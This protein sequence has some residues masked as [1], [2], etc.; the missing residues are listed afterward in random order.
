MDSQGFARGTTIFSPRRGADVLKRFGLVTLVLGMAGCALEPDSA[1]ALAGPSELGLSLEIS[2]TP[3]ILTQDG[4]SKA[5]IQVVAR[6]HMGQ[7]ASGVTLRAETAVGQTI[8]DFGTLSTSV[9]STGSD[10]RTQLTYTAPPAPPPGATNDVVVS[11]LVTPVG[12]NYSNSTTRTVTIRLAR[13]GT[14]LPPNGTPVPKFF[15]SP[16]SPKEGE[17]VLFDGSASTDDGTIVSYTWN[18]GDGRVRTGPRVFH[19]Y[20]LAG[21]YRVTLTVTDD[22]GFTA[23]SAPTDVVVAAADAPTADFTFSPTQPIAGQ[24]VFFNG[25]V[26]KAAVGA[27]IKSYRWDFGDG[28][29]A[30]GSTTQHA[31]TAAGTYTVVLVVTDTNDKV[32]AV[33]KTLLIAP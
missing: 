2:A 17:A 4:V 25:E 20:D 16:V 12:S 7:P 19:S 6:D 1:P 18:L 14:I 15:Y 13:P 11:V 8:V 27:E 33:S 5:V 28:T 29:I 3:D 22:R 21:T 32:H 30:G 24:T 26:S 31:Y 9:V 23:T 10:G